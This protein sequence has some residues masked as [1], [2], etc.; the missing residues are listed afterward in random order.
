MKVL[1]PHLNER[2]KETLID[3]VTSSVALYEIY[4][5]AFSFPLERFV[6][7]SSDDP[8]QVL[9]TDQLHL[10]VVTEHCL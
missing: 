8:D 10:D 9:Q 1:L 2:T 5:R 3:Q 6:V 7:S 4:M